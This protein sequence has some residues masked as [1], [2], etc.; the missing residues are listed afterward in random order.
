[1]V[2]KKQFQFHCS[3]TVV[4]NPGPQ[5]GTGM[6][7][8]WYGVAQEIFNYFHFIYYLNCKIFLFSRLHLGHLSVKI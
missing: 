4:P 6:W 8:N 7:I 3:N 2:Q 5:T 1:M